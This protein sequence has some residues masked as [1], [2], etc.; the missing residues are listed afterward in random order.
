MCVSN[1]AIELQAYHFFEK[2]QE[3]PVYSIIRV[4]FIGGTFLECTQGISLISE[5]QDISNL[6]L[7]KNLTLQNKEGNQFHVEPDEFGLRFAVGDLDYRR[8]LSAKKKQTRYLL[9]YTSGFTVLFTTM[10]WAF[11]NYFL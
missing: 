1:N 7:I 9:L 6:P 10:G 2:I 3:S 11:I 5:L 4:D 8:Y